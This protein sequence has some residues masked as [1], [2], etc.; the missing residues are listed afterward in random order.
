MYLIENINYTN[1][2][3]VT[4]T[5]D[6]YNWYIEN[7]PDYDFIVYEY[8][9]NKFIY[10]TCSDEIE[11]LGTMFAIVHENVDGYGTDKFDII[12]KYPKHKFN[13][14]D[15][16]IEVQSIYNNTSKDN[17]DIGINFITMYSGHNDEP[18]YCYGEYDA[19]GLISWC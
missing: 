16:P 9:N 18:I 1:H 5:E 17:I 6:W 12:K 13:I 2:V 10:T 8:K 4:M 14:D 19:Q 3:P 15:M 11:P 7:E